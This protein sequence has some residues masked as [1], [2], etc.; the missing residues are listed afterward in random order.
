MSMRPKLLFLDIETASSK[1]QFDELNN[2][3]KE[4]W[5][6]KIRYYA[7]RD[8]TKTA[9]DLYSEKSAIYA[10]FGK[11]IC[12]S[13]G[14]KDENKFRVKSFIG[15]EKALLTNFFDLV[16]KSY[17]DARQC[18]FVGH[19]IKEF[20]IPYLCRRSVIH[21]IRIPPSFDLSG[22]KPW[23]VLHIFD[24]LEMWKFGDYKNFTSLDLLAHCLNLPTS[25]NDISGK[26]V[27]V[28][29]WKDNDIQ[30][31]AN[32][33]Q[34]DVVLTARV[35]HRLRYEEDIDESNVIIVE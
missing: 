35:F 27:G 22:R 31:I 23:E 6:Q 9:S 32:Y 19:N 20:D 5:A 7:E 28:V 30:R 14:I 4:L 13:V 18:S 25:K 10:E 29:Y 21:G 3:E 2:Q 26:D 11:V 15:E 24:T 33:C 12:I 8:L 1:A 16:N 17:S 34:K